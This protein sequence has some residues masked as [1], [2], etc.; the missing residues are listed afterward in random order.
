MWTRYPGRHM[1]IYLAF[2]GPQN[3][4][5]PE[6]KRI[7]KINNFGDH[8]TPSIVPPE[9]F[10]QLVQRLDKSIAIMADI[11][12]CMRTVTGPFVPIVLSF[13]EWIWRTPHQLL[14][15]TIHLVGSPQGM[16]H[17]RPGPARH[18]ILTTPFEY[19]PPLIAY[20]NSLSLH[21]T[22][23]N[24]PYR[25]VSQIL[26]FDHPKRRTLTRLALVCVVV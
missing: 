26:G 18:S 21:R 5:G 10:I 7:S 25:A 11:H 20:R 9:A 3:P 17:D 2:P 15:G 23:I 6:E 22:G 24:Q 16:S 1:S 4:S 8:A 19:L 14:K 13:Q 12:V